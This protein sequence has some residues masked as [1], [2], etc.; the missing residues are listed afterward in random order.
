MKKLIAVLCC[1]LLLTILYMPSAHGDDGTISEPRQTPA[2]EGDHFPCGIEWWWLY[3]TLTL[4]DGSQWDMCIMFFY[5]M[6][7]STDHWSNTDGFSYIRIESW[8]RKTGGYYDCLH[9]DPH[10]GPFY[11][12]KNYVNLS[13]DNS[14]FQGLYP[15]YTV[16]FNDDVNNIT[17]S[18]D[19]N[20]TAPPHFIGQDAVNGTMPCGSGT[21]HYWLMPLGQITGRLTAGNQTVN[22]TGIGY[23]EHLFA[24]AHFYDTF[25]RGLGIQN[26]AKMSS[27]YGGLSK[28][29]FTQY[30]QNGYIDWTSYHTSTDCIVG[31]DW[32]WMGFP[33][34]WSMILY[35]VTALAT[36]DGPSIGL[37]IVTDGTTYWEF[38]DITTKVLRDQYL[39]DRDVYLPMDF[40]I[41]A[42]KGSMKIHAFFRST[43]EITKMY[44]KAGFFELGNFLV[45]GVANGT[46]EQNGHSITL[47][48]GKGTNT[49]MRFIPRLIKHV[50]NNID[51]ILPPQ[52]IG[53]ILSGSN[54]YLYVEVV[55]KIQIEP[56]FDFEFT[57]RPSP[58]CPM[59]WKYILSRIY[60]AHYSE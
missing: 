7:W 9:S 26:I 51:W 35:R 21:F 45:A 43:T 53:V 40:E 42:G 6:N 36:A 55:I 60:G 23:M 47:E 32:I 24:D 16:F 38:A 11:H 57:V 27:L 50:S 48:N 52:G 49:P 12:E 22:V 56:V 46:V 1:G 58:N 44:F 13:Y 34:G 41:S 17:M 25:F 30:L 3:T 14:T 28:W 18:I 20:A 54:H 19:F 10:P 8:D 31:Y 39:G 59:G 33:S 37:L 2:D 15:Y 5:Q 4:Q 29:I